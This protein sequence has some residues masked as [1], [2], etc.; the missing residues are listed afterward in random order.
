MTQLLVVILNEPAHL[1]ALLDAWQTLGVPGTTILDSASARRAKGWLHKVG[2]S[3]V[4]ELLSSS[5][6]RNKTLLSIIDDEDL[7]E[8][9]ISAVEEITGDLSVPHRGLQFVIPI[10]RVEGLDK[11]RPEKEDEAASATATPAATTPVREAALITR[12]TPASVVNEILNLKPTIVQTNAD[13]LAVAE[14]MSQNPSVTVACVVNNRQWLVGLLPLQHLADD[15]FLQ[16]IPE[17][18]LS[19]STDREGALHFADLSRTQP[20][21]EAMIPA[22]SVKEGDRI[23]DI[24]H[25]MHHHTLSGIPI[26]NEQNQVIG[27]INLIELLALYCRSQGIST[28]RGEQNNG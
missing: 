14:A 22:V 2:L 17:E 9:A 23:R 4:S 13:L 20:A 19:D 12:N 28:D 24:F 18:F 25:K 8:Q 6:V 27:Y 21:G 7:L 16:V 1:P 15:L 3:A 10:N 11:S 26:V 5:E